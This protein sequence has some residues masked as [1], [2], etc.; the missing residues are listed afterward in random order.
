MPNPPQPIVEGATREAPMPAVI[1]IGTTSIERPIG[2][3]VTG[4]W[5]TAKTIKEVPALLALVDEGR[6]RND[7]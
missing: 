6:L 5:T 7:A 4:L 1:G 2:E 3:E